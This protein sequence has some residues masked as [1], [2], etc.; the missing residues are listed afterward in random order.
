MVQIEGIDL[1]LWAA[2]G[3]GQSLPAFDASTSLAYGTLGAVVLLG[4]LIWMAT[5]SVRK[6]LKLQ[7][8]QMDQQQALLEKLTEISEKSFAGQR[9]VSEGLLM[10]NHNLSK[11]RSAE[12]QTG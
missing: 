12:R 9:D 11:K 10:L 4:L 7:R 6:Q 1:G 8:S 2:P 3:L 5:L